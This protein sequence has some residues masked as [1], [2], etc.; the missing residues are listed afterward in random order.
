M[1]EKI[2]AERVTKYFLGGAA[3][4]V[5]GGIAVAAATGAAPFDR[6]YTVRCLG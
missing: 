1:K 4:I 3:I 5:V 2:T 6:G